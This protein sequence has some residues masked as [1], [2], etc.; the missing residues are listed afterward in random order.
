MVDSHGIISTLAG[1]SGSGFS[2]D[3]GAASAAAL[4]DPTGVAVDSAGNVSIADTQNNRVR[5]VYASTVPVF[6]QAGVTNGAS[7]AAGNLVPGSIAALFGA[8]LTSG[9]GIDLATALPLASDLLNV[10]VTTDG[11]AAPIFAVDNVN[12]QQ[13][14]N[15][16]VPWELAGK[17]S[18]ILQ[19]T[20]NGVLSPAIGAPVV[21]A[22]PGIFT[23]YAGATAFGA[24]LHSNFQL[25]DTAHPATA[26]ETVLIYCTGLGAVSPQPKDGVAAPASSSTVVVPTV[27]IGGMAAAISYHGLAPGFVGLYQINAAVPGGLASGNQQVI[28]TIGGAVSNAPYLPVE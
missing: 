21:A 14:I 28:I 15:F 11:I 19:V 20:S 8:D 27:T 6:A 13:Q 26:G 1:V 4:N 12:G 17:S 9:S 18:A 7:Y 23:Y 25:A 24:I 16:Q 10:S 5:A 22:Q 3:G 2:G